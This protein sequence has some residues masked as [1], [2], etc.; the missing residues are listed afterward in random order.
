MQKLAI[1]ANMYDYE[2]LNT[3]QNKTFLL[4]DM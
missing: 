1:F 4:R 2:T 3:L